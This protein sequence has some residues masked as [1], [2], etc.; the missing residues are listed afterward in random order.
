MSQDRKISFLDRATD[1]VSLSASDK[2]WLSVSFLG[3]MSVFWVTTVN[4][5]ATRCTCHHMGLVAQLPCLKK[6]FLDLGARTEFTMV[7]RSILVIIPTLKQL[8]KLRQSVMDGRE[9]RSPAN[10]DASLSGIIVN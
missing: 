7:A 5:W 2:C 6:T 10:E 9:A 4:V 3:N 1:E 8:T